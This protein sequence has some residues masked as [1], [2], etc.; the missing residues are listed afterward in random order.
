MVTLRNREE[1]LP[2]CDDMRLHGRRE[3]SDLPR[4]TATRERA[5]GQL[6][7]DPVRREA[8]R[9]LEPDERLR[10]RGRETAVDGGRIEPERDQLELERRDVPA[11]GA[12]AELALAEERLPERAE[13]PASRPAHLARSRGCPSVCWKRVRPE[14]VIGPSTPSTAAGY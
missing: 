11:D 2:R 3:R 1:A 9:G 12:D 10:R 5:E 6:P 8:V 14:R 4:R 13:R 7:G